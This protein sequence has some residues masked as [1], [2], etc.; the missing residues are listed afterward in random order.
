MSTSR[1]R[2]FAALACAPA[3]WFPGQVRPPKDNEK[4]YGLLRVEAV[5]GMDPE[6]AKRRPHFDE[7]TPIFPREM[8][9][10]ETIPLE[11]FWPIDQ[12]DRAHRARPAR[13]DR[14]TA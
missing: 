8:F 12:P 5:N 7:L 4:Y 13:L 3:T 2:R 10:L 9:N 6:V 1:S 14:L 11:H